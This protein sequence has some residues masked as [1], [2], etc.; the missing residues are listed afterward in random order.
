MDGFITTVNSMSGESGIFVKYSRV[1]EYF[2]KLDARMYPSWDGVDFFPYMDEYPFDVWTGY[3]S[4]RPHVKKLTRESDGLQRSLEQ[5]SSFA[6]LDERKLVRETRFLNALFQH[7]DAITG[8]HNDYTNANYIEKFANHSKI[9]QKVIRQSICS[10][11]S[12][13]DVCRETIFLKK[14]ALSLHNKESRVLILYN[15][16]PWNR[17][18]FVK[19]QTLN[20]NVEI[21]NMKNEVV[22]SQ[23]HKN[24]DDFVFDIVFEADLPA[25][26]VTSYSIHR[27]DNRTDVIEPTRNL[28][29]NQGNLKFFFREN[30]YSSSYYSYN[31]KTHLFSQQYYQYLSLPQRM[32]G[33]GQYIFR[34][35]WGMFFLIGLGIGVIVGFLGMIGFRKHIMNLY[36]RIYALSIALFLSFWILHLVFSLMTDDMYLFSTNS[37]LHF[38]FPFGIILAIS[39]ILAGGFKNF[40]VFFVFGLLSL[41]FFNFGHPEFLARHIPTQNTD[42]TIFNGPLTSQ[43]EQNFDSWKQV[44]IVYKDRSYFDIRYS[45]IHSMN[46]LITRIEMDHAQSTISTDSN[47]LLMTERTFQPLR[48]MQTNYYPVTSRV[49]LDARLTMYPSHS[50][51]VT[52][53]KSYFDVMLYRNSVVDDERG[54][55]KLI[56]DTSP[57]ETTLRFHLEPTLKFKGQLEMNNPILIY[58]VHPK[59]NMAT[60]K[61]NFEVHWSPIDPKYQTI[62]GE[63]EIDFT[64]Q[65]KQGK[66]VLRFF[67][68]KEHKIQLDL[69]HL[70]TNSEVSKIAKTNLNL[71]NPKPS[72]AIVKIDSLFNTYTCQVKDNSH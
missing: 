19:I 8:T 16:L 66:N 71:L 26:G 48:F 3:Y 29:I 44:T 55:D 6:D 12:K 5:L 7:H 50:L 13:K 63:Q 14:H 49:D 69:Q 10:I 67:N 47:G 25:M 37:P 11:L 2:A 32:F 42:C 65:Y 15:P 28:T 45:N 35:N 20:T 33:N 31:G 30:D 24:V 21:R 39:L 62:F 38:G 4:L 22:L 64:S 56:H 68:P 23:V 60:W 41:A 54:L 53:F 61:A 59:Y 40:F 52:R 57:S 70:F 46:D 51:G 72:P 58:D 17:R 36:N 1:S 43:F 9:A 18:D 34:V 27:I